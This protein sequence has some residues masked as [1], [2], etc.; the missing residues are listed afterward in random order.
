MLPKTGGTPVLAASAQAPRYVATDGAGALAWAGPSAVFWSGGPGA[1][2]I[3]A[4]PRGENVSVIGPVMAGGLVFWLQPSTEPPQATSQDMLSWFAGGGQD[5]AQGGGVWPIPSV[6]PG[7][8]TADGQHVYWADG[9]DVFRTSVTSG[10]FDQLAS[11]GPMPT[12]CAGA[13]GAYV[14][15][16]TVVDLLVDA[17]SVYS[18]EFWTDC[19]GSHGEVRAIAK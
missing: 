6:N 16:P 19:N 17:L 7:A 15:V 12:A 13:P 1:A 9:G 10:S 3:Q 11:A 4:S 8:L 5:G 14:G 2:V 18:F